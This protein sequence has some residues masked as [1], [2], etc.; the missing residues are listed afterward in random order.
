MRV[1]IKGKTEMVEFIKSRCWHLLN[2]KMKNFIFDF[3]IC[4]NTYRIFDFFSLS[5][6]DIFLVLVYSSLVILSN[7]LFHYLQRKCETDNDN[8]IL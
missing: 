8:A 4:L 7:S 6:H 1:G 2:V 5:Y 3:R